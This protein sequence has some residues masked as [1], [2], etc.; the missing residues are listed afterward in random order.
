MPFDG[1]PNL[2][3]KFLSGEVRMNT[4]SVYFPL[5]PQQEEARRNGDR[6][7]QCWI[8]TAVLTSEA[9]YGP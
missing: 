7:D 2:D 6:T 9:A 8:V 4:F 1:L 3:S 5:A